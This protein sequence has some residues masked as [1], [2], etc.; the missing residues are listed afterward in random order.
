MDKFLHL[1]LSGYVV[2]LFLDILRSHY[3]YERHKFL[4]F[5]KPTK[6]WIDFFKDDHKWTIGTL[7]VTLLLGLI[8]V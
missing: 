7:I 5:D 2:L 1:V 4:L 6:K 8:F 3:H